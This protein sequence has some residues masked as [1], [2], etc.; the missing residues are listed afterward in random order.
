MRVNTGS[1]QIFIIM[2][3]GIVNGTE[4]APL[5]S[6][7]AY[8]SNY[9]G[10]TFFRTSLAVYH[11]IYNFKNLFNMI[12]KVWLFDFFYINLNYTS[13]LSALNHETKAA[14]IVV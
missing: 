7:L 1:V 9:D 12:V 8:S 13:V 2:N 5:L 6:A 4:Q 10:C 14:W 11:T 3:A